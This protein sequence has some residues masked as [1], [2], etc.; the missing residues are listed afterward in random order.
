MKYNCAVLLFKEIYWLFIYASKYFLID[1]RCKTLHRIYLIS[2][3]M[4][5]LT[6][7]HTLW[8]MG[9]IFQGFFLLKIC[10]YQ[11]HLS[12]LSEIKYKV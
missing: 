11:K 10:K 7:L 2:L 12:I 3:Q 5:E 6:E 1:H 4:S 8:S 9:E